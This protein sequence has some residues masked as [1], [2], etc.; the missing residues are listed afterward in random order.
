MVGK[1]V[2]PALK[3]S[4]V[5]YYNVKLLQKPNVRVTFGSFTARAVVR[6]VSNNL[7]RVW[8][9]QTQQKSKAIIYTSIEFLR[10]PITPET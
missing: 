5:E 4:A 2:I 6:A 8:L 10:V 3:Q 7:P 1:L 9:S